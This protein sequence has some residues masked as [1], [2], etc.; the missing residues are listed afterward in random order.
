MLHTNIQDSEL[1]IFNKT[2][3]NSNYVTLLSFH[4]IFPL[5]GDHWNSVKE[6]FCYIYTP[7]VFD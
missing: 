4:Q 3:Q 5:G 7:S 2:L 6:D 1:P